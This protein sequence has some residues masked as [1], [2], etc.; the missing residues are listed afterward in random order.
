LAILFRALAR[1]LVWG[2]LGGLFLFASIVE[3]DRGTLDAWPPLL[4]A[5]A[6]TL[7]CVTAILAVSWALSERRS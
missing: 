2:T 6:A 3:C 5:I 1:S 7:T 4:F